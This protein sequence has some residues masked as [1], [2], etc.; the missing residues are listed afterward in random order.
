MKRYSAFYEEAEDC[1]YIW[2]SEEA[3]RDWQEG[4]SSTE[5]YEIVDALNEDEY[6]EDGNYEYV[7]YY[8]VPSLVGFVVRDC[9]TKRIVGFHEYESDARTH[10]KKL[11][12]PV[13]TEDTS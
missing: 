9:A 5:V 1:W 11:N 6:V 2:D 4:R 7:P 8:T 13:D 12:R 10:C 3:T